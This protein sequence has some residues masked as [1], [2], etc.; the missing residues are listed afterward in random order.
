MLLQLR[1]RIG[2]CFQ[3]IRV[4]IIKDLSKRVAINPKNTLQFQKEQSLLHFL[5]A[6]QPSQ[7]ETFRKQVAEDSDI[8][9]NR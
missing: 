4:G 3:L 1:W 7:R 8:P 9:K 6:I 5:K 2:I